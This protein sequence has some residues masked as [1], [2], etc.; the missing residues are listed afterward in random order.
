MNANAAIK[1]LGAI[2]IGIIALGSTSQGAKA[3]FGFFGFGQGMRRIGGPT[4]VSIT[5]Y[6]VPYF[7]VSPRGIQNG[8]IGP[9]GSYSQPADPRSAYAYPESSQIGATSSGSLIAPFSG[10]GQPAD[11]SQTGAQNSNLTGKAIPRTSDIFEAKIEKDNNLFIKWT[12][13]PRLVS[14]ITFALLDKDRKP[15]KQE[16]IT[17]LP[18]QARLS[19]TSKTSYYQVYVEYVNGTTTNV[20]SPL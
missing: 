5:G 6:D 15:L 17:K 9:N 20:I 2:V 7:Q 4:A 10:N 19:I 16:K 18:T 12:G 13:E 11:S 3:Q 8:Y 1:G 14:S